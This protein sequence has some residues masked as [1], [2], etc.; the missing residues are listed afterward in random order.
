MMGFDKASARGR[1]AR[2]SENSF[3]LISLAGGFPGVILGGLIFH[4]KTSKPQFWIP[5][6]AA[7]LIW[8]G[9]LLFVLKI[10]QF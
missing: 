8:G 10:I 4:H 3:G 7:V 2:I 5:V 9:L 1:R 6:A